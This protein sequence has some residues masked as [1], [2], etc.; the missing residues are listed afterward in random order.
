MTSAAFVAN[1]FAYGSTT[2]QPSV[3]AIVYSGA[4]TKVYRGGNVIGYS[5]GGTPAL[6]SGTFTRRYTNAG[7]AS[8]AV[9]ASATPAINVLPAVTGRMVKF[10][11]RV[12]PS[13]D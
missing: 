12:Q 2:Q 7:G 8:I 3:A 9:G 4:S 11:W 13:L 6:E 1:T 5:A 10:G